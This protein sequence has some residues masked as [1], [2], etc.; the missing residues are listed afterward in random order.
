MTGA[1]AVHRIMMKNN[2]KTYSNCCTFF[3]YNVI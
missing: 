3:F 1:D 2:E